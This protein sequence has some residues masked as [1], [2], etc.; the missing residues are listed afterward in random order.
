MPSRRSRI[1]FPTCNRRSCAI[2]RGFRCPIATAHQQ[3]LAGSKVVLAI[4]DTLP[5]RLDGLGVFQ[6]SSPHENRDW[7]DVNGP[8]V[9]AR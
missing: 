5:H 1:R 8:W 6:R 2:I 4:A 3:Q 9:S 7:Q